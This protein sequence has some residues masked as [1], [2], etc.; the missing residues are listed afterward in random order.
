ME[1]LSLNQ[2]AWRNTLIGDYWAERNM[3]GTKIE[4]GYEI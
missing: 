1:M 2:S 3:S 4:L